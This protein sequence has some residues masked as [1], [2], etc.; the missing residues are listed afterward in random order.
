M[1]YGEGC[2]VEHKMTYRHSPTVRRP[3]KGPMCFLRRHCRQRLTRQCLVT[4]QLHQCC[5]LRLIPSCCW[6]RLRMLPQLSIRPGVGKSL[7]ASRDS[8]LRCL[9]GA[10]GSLH[11]CIQ[12]CWT[13]WSGKKE[14]N[15]KLVQNQ[16]P[17]LPP[18]GG[19]S[20]AFHL[21]QA[22]TRALTVL[23]ALVAGL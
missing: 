9:S 14:T 20:N 2:K 17:H 6:S 8:D 10:P 19:D 21:E 12:C 16:L 7:Q 22:E 5:F 1:Q 18:D 13:W 11:S 15:T 4:R 23:A 3:G